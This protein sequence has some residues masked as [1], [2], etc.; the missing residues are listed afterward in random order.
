M[1][2]LII[3]GAAAAAAGY[4]FSAQVGKVKPLDKAYWFGAN[5]FKF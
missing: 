2:K 4:F 1:K 3:I 5:G